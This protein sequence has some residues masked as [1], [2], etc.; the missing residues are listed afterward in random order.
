MKKQISAALMA[1]M[2]V[3]Q[4]MASGFMMPLN[5][6]A[7]E[8][9]P[10][11]ENSSVSSDT[12]ATN[13]TSDQLIKDEPAVKDKAE[14]PKT[15]KVVNTEDKNTS[16]KAEAGHQEA[17][18]DDAAEVEENK[19]AT[20]EESTSEEKVLSKKE[21]KTA[22]AEKGTPES[23]IKEITI[24]LNDKTTPVKPGDVTNVTE[25]TY[26]K[27]KY[28]FLI[29]VETYKNGDQVAYK[30]PSN[31][32]WEGTSP[33]SGPLGSIGTFKIDNGI[34]TFTFNKEIENDNGS[35]GTPG[36]IS[37]GFVAEANVISQETTSLDQSFT[38][39]S[40]K[41]EETYNLH[42]SPEGVNDDLTKKGKAGIIE[43]TTFKE[44][45]SKQNAIQWIVEFNKTKNTLKN[46]V[47]KDTFDTSKL[48]LVPGTFKAIE[49]KVDRKGNVTE[50]GDVTS[51][52]TKK[53]TNEWSIKE[54]SNK[55]YRIT[56]VTKVLDETV[57]TYTNKANVKATGL[58]KSATKQ[59]NIERAKLLNKY[60][61]ATATG[62]QWTIDYNRGQTT[63]PQSKAYI[64]DA[65][66]GEQILDEDSIT[67]YGYT[68]ATNGSIVYDNA[69]LSKDEY[70]IAKSSTEN[71]FDIIFKKDVTKSYMISYSTKLY[72]GH[73]V[74]DDQTVKN[75]VTSDGQE[76]SATVTNKQTS[77]EKGYEKLDFQ[78]RTAT[79]VITVNKNNQNIRNA[80]VLDKFMTENMQYIPGTATVNG[81]SV[82]DPEQRPDGLLF[83]LGDITKKQTIKIDVS[84]DLM[85]TDIYK[86]KATL[87]FENGKKIETTSQFERT[88]NIKNNG[89]KNV[90]KDLNNETGEYTFKWQVGFG[91]NLQGVP[92]G[93][94][95]TDEFTSKNMK[96]KEDTFKIMEL[97]NKNGHGNVVTSTEFKDYTLETNENGY[98]VTFPN[99]TPAGKAYVIQYDTKDTDNVY[100]KDYT[101]KA[102]STIFGKD[103]KEGSF[104]AHTQVPNG[105]LLI[106]KKGK[107]LR[108]TRHFDYSVDI[109][110]SKSVLKKASVTDSLTA[111]NKFDGTFVANSFKL[112]NGNIELTETNNPNQEAEDGKHYLYVSEDQT[113]F[114]IIFPKSIHKSYKLDY[115]VY[116]E[117]DKGTELSNLIKLN[118]DDMTED[119]KTTS[120]VDKTYYNNSTAFG[121]GD[122]EY[123]NIYI[124]KVDGATGKALEGAE[125]ELYKYDDYE[126]VYRTATTDKDG[127]AVFENVRL[128]ADGKS[129]YVIKETKAPKNYLEDDS[130]V[131]IEFA[132]EN[133]KE[134]TPFVIKNERKACEV[135]VSFVDAKDKEKI[136]KDGTYTVFTKDK[137]ETKQKVEFKDGEAKVNLKPGTYFIKQDGDIKGIAPVDEF[138]EIKVEEDADG[139]CKVTTV[140]VELVKVCETVILSTDKDTGD[141]ITAN[142]EYKV[143]KDGKDLEKTFKSDDKGNID[144]G[145]LENGKYELVQTKAPEGYVLNETPLE[146]EVDA[147]NCVTDL[148]FENEVPKCAVTVINQDENKKV[149]KTDSTY[150]VVQ[151]DKVI[152][153]EVK[154]VD[155]KL[156]LEPLP[157]GDYTLVQVT[158]D[159]MYVLNETGVDFTVD[160]K[161]CD[162]IVI[163]NEFAKCEITVINKDENGDVIT[164]GSTYKVMQGN[165][166]VVETVTAVDGQIKLPALKHGT[167]QLVQ[168]DVSDKYVLNTSPVEFKINKD[169][170][171]ATVTIKNE[172]AKCDI[173]VINKDVDGGK[174]KD[175]SEYDVYQII[176]DEKVK[177][178]KEPLVSKDGEVK[179]PA[180]VVGKYELVQ[181]KVDSIYVLNDKPVAFEV[182]KDDCKVVQ[183]TNEFAK[184]E[185][186]VINKDENDEVITDDSEYKVMQGD[187]EIAKATAKDGEIKLPA[188][189]HGTY[190]LVQTKVSD[191]YVLNTT[192]VKFTVDKETCN[193]V[194]E[195]KNDLAKC[196]I[197]VINKDVDG[198]KIKDG[199]E[200]DVYQIIGDE[201]VKVNKEPIVSKDGEVK[202]PALVVGKY[203]LVQTKVDS[204][205][206]LNDKP[207][208]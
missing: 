108:Q 42:F 172:I 3:M 182:V 139:D 203:E 99:G 146:F 67:I 44:V 124:K 60:G 199:S 29:P 91:L 48:E 59:V 110:Q 13:E 167:Y 6:I 140:E 171:S 90:T 85:T 178:N 104:T 179:V 102:T 84:L 158:A 72:P 119:F 138:T 142:S 54:G 155:G 131:Q 190:K 2:L 74:T 45:G 195:I 56:Y 152:V 25:Q 94:K 12:D 47:F 109:N 95:I 184:C 126:T 204:I 170:C 206:V 180:L 166:E 132:L 51:D 114:K 57:S 33:K 168:T 151:G 197:T 15:D 164:D 181:T 96:L 46:G 163:T 18:I 194:V 7:A 188:L 70:Y 192:P 159:D 141:K 137:V 160:P 78:K 40:S 156:T 128:K 116:Y 31:F 80:Y 5:A 177:V 17:V 71:S 41:G 173:T 183:I 115:K 125:F 207:V 205:Y 79:W 81:K 76:S 149:I 8:N 92:Q 103:G 83:N 136:E 193:A 186:T 153:K 37:A 53:G 89:F 107:Q 97:D 133:Q 93:A 88:P 113:S 196:D 187:K 100:S 23:I 22:K 101:N 123:K 202:V 11:A 75:T 129:P 176:G 20:T 201:K 98:V 21:A 86:N 19:E 117:G 145:K 38:V 10:V 32:D 157:A 118:Y 165:E 4:L 147:E 162:G 135:T 154:A 55:A 87:M 14:A 52:F 112:D 175:G 73:V 65:I 105:G 143:L 121:W 66:H 127:K 148:K 77:L 43:G 169:E 64:R 63:I 26:F 189:K 106:D 68:L 24:H 62:A 191:K 34:V 27:I 9:A 28:D 200:Y 161:N 185:I 150:K 61:E 111:K 130:Q 58:D 198:G 69:P 30:L 134:A 50:G 36:F 39:N 144:L 208:A 1:L 122:V 16:S 174:I 35:T 49:L 82:K 120:S